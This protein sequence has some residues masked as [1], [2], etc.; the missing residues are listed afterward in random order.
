MK[1]SKIDAQNIITALLHANPKDTKQLSQ[2]D[3]RIVSKA[4]D[5]FSTAKEGVEIDLSAQ[6]DLAKKIK[7]FEALPYSDV[8]Q[9]Q[10]CYLLK[11]ISSLFKAILN[12]LQ[13]RIGSATLFKRLEIARDKILN[14]S[15][16]EYLHRFCNVVTNDDIK[17]VNVL[18]IGSIYTDPV[19]ER[20][21]NHIVKHYA[22]KSGQGENI[23]LL[24]GVDPNGFPKQIDGATFKVECWEQKQLYDEHSKIMDEAAKLLKEFQDKKNERKKFKEEHEKLSPA[25][26]KQAGVKIVEDLERIDK[27]LKELDKRRK[28][29]ELLNVQ[30]LITKINATD[31]KKTTSKIFA[32]VGNGMMENGKVALLTQMSFAVILPK[33]TTLAEEIADRKVKEAIEAGHF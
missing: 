4:I 30:D 25:E 7:E 29:I 22:M 2:A 5:C 21:R 9:P 10:Q 18:F 1:I 20:I 32:F 24:D 27:R 12:G 13:L 8:T 3:R 33:K 28:E 16:D 17:N 11:L 14:Q 15:W 19:T 6:E 26:I 23:I 31:P